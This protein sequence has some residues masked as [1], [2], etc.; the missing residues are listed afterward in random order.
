MITVKAAIAISDR[1]SH[2]GEEIPLRAM[3]SRCKRALRTS[4]ICPIS[5][6][7]NGSRWVPPAA[8]LEMRVYQGYQRAV[9]TIIK[10]VV[11]ICPLLHCRPILV[12]HMARVAHHLGADLFSQLGGIARRERND[13]LDCIGLSLNG[14]TRL[15]LIVPNT[16]GREPDQHCKREAQ[17]GDE[18]AAVKQDTR[19]RHP[20]DAQ[21]DPYSDR[22]DE[23]H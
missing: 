6:S 2:W 13:I 18:D 1:A 8:S 11:G 5:A 3:V 20:Q 19:G 12:Q 14:G 21:R 17:D 7:D 10:I 15:H 23:Y 16:G 22:Y 4:R 9:G